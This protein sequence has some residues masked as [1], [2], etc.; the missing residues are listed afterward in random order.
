MD[1]WIVDDKPAR[2]WGCTYRPDQLPIPEW[3]PY[4]EELC[5][6]VEPDLGTLTGGVGSAQKSTSTLSKPHRQVCLPHRW[7]GSGWRSV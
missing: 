3:R 5:M 6:P 1:I 2:A 4:A 7:E